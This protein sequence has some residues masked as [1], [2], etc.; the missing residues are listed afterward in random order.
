MYRENQYKEPIPGRWAKL[1][2][3]A[4]R[5]RV[6]FALLGMGLGCLIILAIT[7]R[8]VC[9]A[10]RSKPSIPVMAASSEPDSPEI[11]WLRQFAR[12]VALDIE[13]TQRY[14]REHPPVREDDPAVLVPMPGVPDVYWMQ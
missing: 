6:G 10:L 13:R 2:M 7:V 5:R 14:E 4:H 9:V 12:N 11:Q 1:R 3:W 8:G